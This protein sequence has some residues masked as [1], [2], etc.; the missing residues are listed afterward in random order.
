MKLGN[1]FLI[2]VQPQY[3][4]RAKAF[5]V[6]FLSGDIFI[7]DDVYFGKRSAE[8]LEICISQ[9]MDAPTEEEYEKGIWMSFHSDNFEKSTAELQKFGVREVKGGDKSACFFSFPSDPVFKLVN[10]KG[11]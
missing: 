6:E 3:Y 8:G 5:V 4:E 9:E 2:V 7:D 1:E 10:S 11:S